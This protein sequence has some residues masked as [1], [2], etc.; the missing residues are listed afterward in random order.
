MSRSGWAATPGFQPLYI[1]TY[2]Y[3]HIYIYIYIYTPSAAGVG[4]A[5]GA[6]TVKAFATSDLARPELPI[7]DADCRVSANAA[8]G[9]KKLYDNSNRST[10]YYYYF[11]Y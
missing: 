2:M 3:I 5:A 11:Y 1:Y 4:P 6:L 9:T 8:N 10:S 7:A